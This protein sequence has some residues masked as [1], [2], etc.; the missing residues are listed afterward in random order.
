MFQLV[1]EIVATVAI[2]REK[3]PDAADALTTAGVPK[4]HV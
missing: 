4:H 2:D 1:I 3:E